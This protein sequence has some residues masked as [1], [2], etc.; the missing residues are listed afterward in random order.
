MNHVFVIN[1]PLKKI[2]GKWAPRV[3]LRPAAE[4][5]SIIHCLAP[6]PITMGPEPIIS[7]FQQSFVDID[8]EDFL[9]PVGD[10]VA[11]VIA[12]AVAGRLT[13][14]FKILRWNGHNRRYTIMDIEL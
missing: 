6:G 13:N 2:D 14:Q 11:M 1:E 4:H 5:G 10:P 12:G 9:L 3:D 7:T 8:T